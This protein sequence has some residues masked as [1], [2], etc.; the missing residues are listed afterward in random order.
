MYVGVQLSK[1]QGY[2][3]FRTNENGL[4]IRENN[5]LACQKLRERYTHYPVPR[6]VKASEVSRGARK[7]KLRVD[8]MVFLYVHVL[9]LRLRT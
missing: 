1:Q 4:K 6:N 8:I 2:S 9:T 3:K 5:G 7:K